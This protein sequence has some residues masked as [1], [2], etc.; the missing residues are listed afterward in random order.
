ML[1]QFLTENRF[2][3]FLELLWFTGL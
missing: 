3:L 2:T 1:T